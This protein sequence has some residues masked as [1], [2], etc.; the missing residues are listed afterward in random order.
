MLADKSC[1]KCKSFGICK[2]CITVEGFC[3]NY[4]QAEGM[5]FDKDKVRFDLLTLD[6]AAPLLYVAKVLTFGCKKYA[7]NSW[8][9]LDE[10]V[11]RYNGAIDRHL[12]AARLGEVK[13]KDSGLPH[14]AHVAC[15]ALF[16]LWFTLQ[17]N[18]STTR[19][20]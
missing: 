18:I 20:D 17:E 19:L 4:E 15:N 7:D 9:Q 10:A 12:N 1:K 6:M 16:L 8:Q 13:D 2:N 5:K 3:D 11:R 14:M